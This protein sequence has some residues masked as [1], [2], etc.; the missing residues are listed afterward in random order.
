MWAQIAGKVKLALCPWL[1]EWWQVALFLTAR[2]ITTGTIP[3]PAGAFQIDFDFIDHA[4]HIRT[5]QG[6]ERTTGLRPRSVADFFEEFMAALG[7][8]GIELPHFRPVPD[9]LENP[10][11]FAEDT[12]HDSYDASL[13]QR[14]WR[15]LLQVSN[16]FEVHR[17]AFR[18]KSSPVQFWWGGFD[19]SETR[20]SGRL[21][22]P[23]PGANR[24]MRLAEDRESVA[25]GFWPGNEKLGGFVFYSYA[26]PEPPGFKTAAVRPPQAYY[27]TDLREFILPYE[28]VRRAPDPAAAIRDF[29]QSVYEAGATL[30]NW[31]RERLEGRV[32]KLFG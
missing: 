4:V 31:D 1:N 11:P 27:D 14:W 2:G 7:S 18:G 10:I 8:L 19:L 25:A 26:Y 21:A 13:V 20:F 9:E 32:P 3:L 23:P 17:S 30:G 29:L 6:D 12:V 16:V 28:D 22:D 15:L 5:S 24:L